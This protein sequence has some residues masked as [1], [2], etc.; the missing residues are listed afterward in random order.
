MI[1]WRD[2]IFTNSLTSKKAI[3]WIVF[4]IIAAI[5]I[6]SGVAAPENQMLLYVLSAQ[7]ML[8]VLLLW[9]LTCIERQVPVFDLGFVLI[10]FTILYCA[11]PLF[12]FAMTGFQ[13]ADT[14]DYRLRTYD[15]SAS[16]LAE[17]S[18]HHL[19]YI[20]GLIIGYI[21]LRKRSVAIID[22]PPKAEVGLLTISIILLVYISIVAYF[23]ILNLLPPIELPYIMLQINNN[24]SSIKFVLSIALMYYGFSH[25]HNK[26]LRMAVIGYLFF[27]LSFM[28]L[29]Y[30]GR[31][32]FFLTMIAAVMLYHRLVSAFTFK[33]ALFLFTIALMLFIFWGFKKANIFHYFGEYSMWAATNEFTSL[34]GTAYDLY[35]RKEVVGTVTHD[36]NI[37]GKVLESLPE[38]PTS[39]YFNDILL[40]IPS[41]FLAFEK[42]STSQWYLEVIGLKGTGVGMMF[43]VIS[44]GIIGGGMFELLL[45][46]LFLGGAVGLFHN[47]YIRKA[48]WL[49]MNVAYVFIA[50]RIYDSYRAGTGYIFYDI[51]YQLIPCI[52]LVL[53]LQKLATFVPLKANQRV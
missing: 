48:G 24:L 9:Y 12:A 30:H 45:R 21:V 35:M 47:W 51:V 50:V 43:G 8:A 1:E 10:F 3:V 34:F 16:E 46:G 36:I 37:Y 23:Q 40:L 52:T 17:F 53:I 15:A 4:F 20:A 31:T 49:W 22:L 11:Y 41:Q 18:L 42:W 7:V 2:I 32:Y 13:W 14:S 33:Q 26:W 39:L 38:V 5:A 6:I 25:W 19:T 44:Q 27:Q 29:G 28:L